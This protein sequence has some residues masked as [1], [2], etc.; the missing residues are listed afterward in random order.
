MLIIICALRYAS[1]AN[2]TVGPIIKLRGPK[3]KNN[4]LK[5]NAIVIIFRIQYKYEFICRSSYK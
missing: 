2:G 4:D 3:I 1:G 5:L